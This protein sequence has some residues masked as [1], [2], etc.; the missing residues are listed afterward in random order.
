M[1]SSAQSIQSGNSSGSSFMSLSSS[2]ASGLASE[3]SLRIDDSTRSSSSSSVHNSSVH[4]SSGV[5]LDAKNCFSP[6]Q[7]I[8]QKTNEDRAARVTS[9]ER[10]RKR[11][12]EEVAK[13]GVCTTGGYNA[14][15]QKFLM[16]EEVEK[17]MGKEKPAQ[18]ARRKRSARRQQQS[19][20][21]MGRLVSSFNGPENSNS[22]MIQEVN[23]N[24][25]CSVE[26]ST[27]IDRE[28]MLGKSLAGNLP[29]RRLLS[30]GNN[31]SD[32]EG[33]LNNNNSN[34]A[35]RKMES[36]KR[37]KREATRRLSISELEVYQGSQELNRKVLGCILTGEE[38]NPLVSPQKVH[39]NTS[40]FIQ[41]TNAKCPVSERQ[42][43]GSSMNLEDIFN[44]ADGSQLLPP[45]HTVP[46][47]LPSKAMAASDALTIITKTLASASFTKT[48]EKQGVALEQDSV[49]GTAI[50][51]SKSINEDDTCSESSNDCGWLPWPDKDGN[52]VISGGNISNEKSG[53]KPQSKVPQM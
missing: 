49:N 14:V 12:A 13:A 28:L 11:L 52:D 37:D 6:K 20:G 50:L 31:S 42:G 29:A 9:N 17:E 47:N 10:L 18:P 4:N 36:F 21:L 48:C 44:G 26:C 43:S 24:R 7:A 41:S 53:E 46:S 39:T 51:R 32:N 2:F 34:L 22:E 8:N 25:R 30:F 23:L 33:M 40:G 1:W 5:S 15:L 38:D 45:S 16:S 35:P 3:L 19:Q 27:P